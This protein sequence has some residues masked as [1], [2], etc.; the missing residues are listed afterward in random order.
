MLPVTR[1]IINLT[2]FPEEVLQKI[3]E[4]GQKYD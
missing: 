2:G 4:E 3:L 1:G